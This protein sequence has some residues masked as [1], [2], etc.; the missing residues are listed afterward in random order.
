M[1]VRVSDR[2][3]EPLR[4]QLESVEGLVSAYLVRKRVEH[5]AHR[6]KYVLGFCATRALRL[7]SEKRVAAVLNRIQGTVQ[8][9]G[10]TLILSVEGENRR[11]ARK[12]RRI[13]R[14][15]VI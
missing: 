6:P 12:F 7:R 5:L 3:V 9:P 1:S 2:L 4:A 11:F 8:F 13:E 10:E 14:A 15:R